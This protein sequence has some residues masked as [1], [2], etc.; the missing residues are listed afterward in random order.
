MSFA[1]PTILPPSPQFPTLLPQPPLHHPTPLPPY[2]STPGG[3]KFRRNLNR[4]MDD[5]SDE[6]EELDEL[7]SDIRHR[8]TNFLVPIGRAL[9][10]T[11]EKNDADEASD[12]EDDDDDETGP[13]DRAPSA[14]ED[15]D[16][17][18]QDLD[19]DMDDMDDEG[20]GD[21]TNGDLDEM[22]EDVLEDLSR[23]ILSSDI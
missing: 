18:D 19:A 8:G 11:E 23:Q 2:N 3:L 17:N 15:E 5:L 14:D 16:D 1:S 4:E 6:E 20:N 12:E 10:Q 21:T 9:T 22:D 7:N 13:S